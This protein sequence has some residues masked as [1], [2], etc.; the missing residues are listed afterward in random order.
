MTAS[1]LIAVLILILVMLGYRFDRAA[2]TLEQGGLVQLNSIPSGASLTIDAVRLGATTSTKTTLA[3]GRH[4]ITMSRDGYGTWQKTVEVKSGTIL[5]LNY[6]RLIPTD[7][8]VEN[9]ATLPG[10]TSSIPSPN[11]QWYAMTAEKTSPTVR[12]ANIDSDNPDVRTLT[13]PEDT[14]TVSVNKES[15]SF[16]LSAWD[17]SSRYLLLEHRYDEKVEWLVVDT[18]N[19]ENT[20]NITTT[21]DIAITKPQFSQSD[22]YVLYALIGND[23]RR[24]DIDAA[25][26]SAP[27]VRNVAEFSF[28]DSSTLVYVTKIDQTTKSRS[29]GYRQDGATK[30]RAIRTYSDDGSMPLHISLGE[31]YNETYVGI[32]YGTTVDILSGSLPRSDSDD[33]L[34]LTAVATMSTSEPIDYLSNKTSGRFFVAQHDNNFSVYDLELQKATTTKL[35]GESQLKTELQWLDGYIVWSGLGGTLRFYEFDGANQNDIMPI[36]AGQR[37]ALSPNDR[38][39]YAPTVDKEGKFHLSRI[40]LIL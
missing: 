28:F 7:L 33:P 30:P 19:I 11:R 17:P 37:P 18:Q 38:Y 40:R 22:N 35:R 36:V 32:A 15:E 2:G 12:L 13:L 16:H 6:A 14:Y 27:L 23:I 9:L 4:T 24:I 3:P 5:W 8:P 1:V 39:L 20:K 34:S 29:V 21:F 26:I 31:Y 10:V 25:T